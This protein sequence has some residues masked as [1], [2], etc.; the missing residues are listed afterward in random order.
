M[1]SKTVLVQIVLAEGQSLIPAVIVPTH[2]LLLT[3]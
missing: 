1:H 3:W 2:Y